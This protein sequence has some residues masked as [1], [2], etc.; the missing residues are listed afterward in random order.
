MGMV[1]LES[2]VVVLIRICIEYLVY[3][4]PAIT[5]CLLLS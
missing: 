3:P 1:Y 4:P 2:V 5:H